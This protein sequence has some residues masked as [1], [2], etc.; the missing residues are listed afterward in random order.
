[1]KRHL[2]RAIKISVL[3]FTLGVVAQLVAQTQSSSQSGKH[4]RYRLVDIGTFAGPASS[5]AD[6]NNRGTA[7]GWENAATTDPLCF[8]APDNCFTTHAFQERNGAI[9]D[10]GV[11]PGVRIFPSMRESPRVPHLLGAVP[12]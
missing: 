4:P 3:L 10:L 5:F 9:T 1:M 8:F 6:L 11:L 2:S 7:V 12:D